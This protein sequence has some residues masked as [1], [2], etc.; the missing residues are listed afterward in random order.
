MNCWSSSA[1]KL[2]SS[3]ST[4]YL[5]GREVPGAAAAA[6]TSASAS[7]A[8]SESE[9]ADML[10][11]AHHQQHLNSWLVVAAH[12]ES[13]RGR[14]GRSRTRSGGRCR[15]R[16]PSLPPP[17]ANMIEKHIM[18]QRTLC[19]GF[20]VPL[21]RSVLERRERRIKKEL[22]LLRRRLR[23]AGGPPGSG[24]PERS[25]SL[26]SVVKNRVWCRFCR[27]KGWAV[28]SL[29]RAADFVNIPAMRSN[30]CNF[31][32]AMRPCLAIGLALWE[33]QSPGR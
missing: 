27:Q 29:C 21:V 2:F 31:V 11:P 33:L 22:L 6:S 8:E 13:R 18:L 9:R 32:K 25:E 16:P 19:R 23:R 30:P 10:P 28:S 14:A 4:W 15:R 5:V 24:L 3:I 26:R 17:A 20:P 12:P 1:V 7:A